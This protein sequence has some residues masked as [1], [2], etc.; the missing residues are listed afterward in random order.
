MIKVF[1][2]FRVNKISNITHRL[3]VIVSSCGDW[4]FVAVGAPHCIVAGSFCF[5]ASCWARASAAVVPIRYAPV[6]CVAVVV[7]MKTMDRTRGVVLE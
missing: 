6:T 3:V 2:Y 5:V 7:V 1:F 4:A